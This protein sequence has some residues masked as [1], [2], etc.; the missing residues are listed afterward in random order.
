MSTG[1]TGNAAQQREAADAGLWLQAHGDVLWRYA[2][3][4]LRDPELAEE[5]IQEALVAAIESRADFRG[6]CSERTWLLSILRHKMIDHLRRRGRRISTADGAVPGDALAGM[7]TRRGCW[8]FDPG[9]AP[10]PAEADSPEFLAD[11]ER[12]LAKLPAGL[13]EAFVMREVRGLPSEAICTAARITMENLWVR[14]HRARVL[15]RRCLSPR[16]APARKERC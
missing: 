14:L 2:V 5:L 13:A 16:W 7:Y 12:C 3:G 11:L 8:R 10:S 9:A 4:R 6:E 15:L 1:S